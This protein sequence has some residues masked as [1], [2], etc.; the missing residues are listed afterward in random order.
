MFCT[1]SQCT[2][3]STSRIL[4]TLKLLHFFGRLKIIG[5]TNGL[6]NLLL[7]SIV[8]C[9]V[10]VLRVY[11]ESAQLHPK[12]VPKFCG[13]DLGPDVSVLTADVMIDRYKIIKLTNHGQYVN[14]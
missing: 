1:S 3:E 5:N 9:F 8:A 12:V 14:K 10:F 6:H 2:R 11:G 13:L 4:Q 7:G